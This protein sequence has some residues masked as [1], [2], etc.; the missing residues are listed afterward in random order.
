MRGGAELLLSQSGFSV[1][2][3]GMV[4]FDLNASLVVFLD[5]GSNLKLY[6]SE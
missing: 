3:R 4:F 6:P 5:T 1:V 2:G